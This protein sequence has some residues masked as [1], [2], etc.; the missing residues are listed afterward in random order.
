MEVNFVISE[1]L[2]DFH[3]GAN[4]SSVASVSLNDDVSIIHHSHAC[5]STPKP[6]K[7][8]IEK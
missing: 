7:N 8:K 3:Y 1:C 6:K 2:Y 5:L 4:L